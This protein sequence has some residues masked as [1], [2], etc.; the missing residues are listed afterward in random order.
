MNRAFFLDK[1]VI[2]TG[3]A[4]GIGRE[5]ARL[6]LA[7]GARVVL[8]GR[9]PEALQA[10][11]QTLGFAERTLAVVADV[12]RP[13]EADSLVATVL[14]A[15]G[16]VDVLIN[17]AGLSMRGTFFDLSNDTAR[18]MVDANLLSAVWTTRAALPSL[19]DSR[20]RVVFVSSLAGLRGFPGVS[21]YSSSKM[22]L[23]GLA[24]SL[25]AEEGAG[26]VR[27]GLVYLAFTENDPGKTVLASDGHPF[28]HERP[29]SLTQIQAAEALL[30][31]AAS[32]RRRT[33]LTAT[34][35]LFSAAQAWFPGL[36]DRIV[37]RSGGRLHQVE[38]KRP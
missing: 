18:A 30:R 32:G 25:R 24:E 17:N 10:T 6:A 4:R 37:A 16:R 22:A 23:T 26:G 28:R 1:V 15:W 14:A 13:E 33:V 9:D 12:S 20:G 35:R 11:R 27:V 19:R 3:S 29:W 8:N 7:W 21:L 2:I 38:E 34:G 31:A 5:A 36:M